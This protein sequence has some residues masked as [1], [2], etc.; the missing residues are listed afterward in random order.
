LGG[1][2]ETYVDTSSPT[3]IHM[4]SGHR[5]SFLNYIYWQEKLQFIERDQREYTLDEEDQKVQ[6]V[7]MKP[8]PCVNDSVVL[9]K[10]LSCSY[11]NCSIDEALRRENEKLRMELQRSQAHM[12]VGQCELI[13]RLLD[14]TETAAVLCETQKT[15]PVKS[16]KR[17][18]LNYADE[19]DSFDVESPKKT[20][21]SRLVLMG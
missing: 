10:T 14:V 9:K 7:I 17:S 12:D 2:N 19:K 21:T 18:H 16:P 5:H 1:N 15:S 11:P 20:E 8:D 3:G 6:Q 4:F 13:Q